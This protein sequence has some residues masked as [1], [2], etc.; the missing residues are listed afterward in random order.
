MSEV[1]ADEW[2]AWAPLA[3]LAV[4]LGLAPSQLLW[5]A[6]QAPIVSAV[7]SR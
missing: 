5:S 3:A 4:G 2:V 6:D 7:I 1:Q